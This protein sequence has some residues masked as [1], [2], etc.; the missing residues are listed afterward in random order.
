MAVE[1]FVVAKKLNLFRGF[2]EIFS[3]NLPDKCKI[4]SSG[5]RLIHFRRRRRHNSPSSAN[6]IFPEI[7]HGEWIFQKDLSVKFN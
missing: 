2:K 1:Q 3:E 7:F 4:S 5:S 6:E